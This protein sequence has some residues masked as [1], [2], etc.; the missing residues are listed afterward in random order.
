MATTKKASLKPSEKKAVWE[1][2][3]PVTR[4]KHLTAAQKETAKKRAAKAGRRYPN[5]VDNMA[6][7]HGGGTASP[8]SEKKTVTKK[9][10]VKKATTTKTKATVKKAPPKKTPSKS[11]TAAKKPTVRKSTIKKPGPKKGSTRKTTKK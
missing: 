6:V 4:H 7:L 8:A 5:M 11:A 3:N 10:T 1:K 2:K 9:P